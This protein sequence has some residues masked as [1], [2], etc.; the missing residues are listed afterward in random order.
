ML[1]KRECL[2]Y[3]KI[4]L[5]FVYPR[6][7]NV[8]IAH[9]SPTQWYLPPAPQV[10]MIAPMLGVIYAAYWWEGRWLDKGGDA[11]SAALRLS[12]A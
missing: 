10:Y 6:K 9:Q 5:G 7:F 2:K 8:A 3:P 4:R 11:L 12:V 1:A